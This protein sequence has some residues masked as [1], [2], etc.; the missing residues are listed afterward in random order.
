MPSNGR[1]GVAPV[2]FVGLDGADWELLDRVMSAGTMPDL[3]RLV[4]QGTAGILE[5][6]HPPLSPI[7]WTTMM[8]GVI[9]SASDPGFRAFQP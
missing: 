6:L 8:T 4:R 9:R 5:T 2:I 3:A 7:V 1:R